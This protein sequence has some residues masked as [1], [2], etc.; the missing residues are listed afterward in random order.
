MPEVI[1]S[2]LDGEVLYG[3]LPVLHL[4]DPFLDMDLHTMDGNA[5]QALVPVSAV[6][7]VDEKD[8]KLSGAVP[9]LD[10]LPRV[11]LH[12]IDG[13]VL[14]AHVVTPASLQRFGSLWDVVDARTGERR[15]VG[16]PYTALK[17]AFY[18]RRWD[19]RPPLER[20]E[21]VAGLQAAERQKLAAIH[22]QRRRASLSGMLAKS[23]GG[24]LG[25]GQAS[26]RS[27]AGARRGEQGQNGLDH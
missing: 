8:V 23:T 9:A 1:V 17:A 27:A 15:L 11:A 21:S 10:D 4:D 13:Q 20:A 22:A 14:R 25:R 5:R 19:T 12:F 6:R 18:V 7:Q 2:F 16:I 3:E 24:L 26:G